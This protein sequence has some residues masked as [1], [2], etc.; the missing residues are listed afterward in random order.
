MARAVLAGQ[1][2][3]TT[4]AEVFARWGAEA[5]PFLEKLDEEVIAALPRDERRRL[6][7]KRR[8]RR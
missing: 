4:V 6:E 7:R 3:A 8:K 5:I 1:N 2:T